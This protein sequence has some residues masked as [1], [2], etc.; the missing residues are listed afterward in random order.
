MEPKIPNINHSPSYEGMLLLLSWA[1]FSDTIPGMIALASLCAI[2][3][4]LI[5]NPKYYLKWFIIYAFMAYFAYFAHVWT[6]AFESKININLPFYDTTIGVIIAGEILIFIKL[7]EMLK[8]G[9]LFILSSL[10]D[11]VEQKAKKII[12]DRINNIIA[13]KA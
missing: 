9:K 5:N 12:N 11:W 6:W 3:A 8:G 1:M 10:K 13:K 7:L 4:W 2:N